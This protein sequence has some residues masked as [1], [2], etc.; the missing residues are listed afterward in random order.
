MWKEQLR[1]DTHVAAWKRAC[2]C[3][4]G[5]SAAFALASPPA[6][7]PAPSLS[8]IDTQIQHQQVILLSLSFLACLAALCAP[9]ALFYR[10]SFYPLLRLCLFMLLLLLLLDIFRDE[11]RHTAGRKKTGGG[12]VSATCVPLPSFLPSFLLTFMRT[13]SLSCR[14]SSSFFLMS[15]FHYLCFLASLLFFIS[16]LL[17]S[18]HAIDVFMICCL[19]HIYHWDDWALNSLLSVFMTL[20]SILQGAICFVG[21]T[22]RPAGHS[23]PLSLH[24]V[25]KV[26]N[27]ELTLDMQ[28]LLISV[29]WGHICTHQCIKEIQCGVCWLLTNQKTWNREEE[30]RQDMCAHV[31]VCVR[32]GRGKEGDCSG[33]DGV[34]SVWMFALGMTFGLT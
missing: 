34:R 20:F 17:F 29:G 26:I 31:C 13:S 12:A 8:H 21:K 32:K 1:R 19:F 28:F 2:T 25:I 9:R 18:A 33:F 14:T 24:F 7:F 15:L 23:I 10:P 16:F 27:Q 11:L 5:L 4:L 3:S 30:E 6:C 22:V